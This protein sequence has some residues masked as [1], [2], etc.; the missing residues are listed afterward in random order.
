MWLFYTFGMHY[1]LKFFSKFPFPEKLLLWYTWNSKGLARLCQLWVFTSL[2]VTGGSVLTCVLGQG[3]PVLCL[4]SSCC[5]TFS[6]SP[7]W[8][9]VSSLMMVA[10]EWK[11]PFWLLPPRV[12]YPTIG[13]QTKHREYDLSIFCTV[14]VPQN[15]MPSL[16]IGMWTATCHSFVPALYPL[17]RN[18]VLSETQ[19][20]LGWAFKDQGVQHSLTREVG[21]W[22][23]DNKLRR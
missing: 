19:E 14:I 3:A 12:K 1:S 9:L 23:L 2:S 17:W 21:I 10:F 5:V 4:T 7:H 20:T 18:L 13:K 16:L 22:P 8:I 15:Q 11:S 6:P